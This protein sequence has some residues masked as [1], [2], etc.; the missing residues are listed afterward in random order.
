MPTTPI[1]LGQSVCTDFGQ[2]A[3]KEWLETNSLGGYASSTIAGLNTR[4]YHGLLI[5]ALEPPT[6][7][8]VLLSKVEERLL[9]DGHPHELSTNQYPGTLFPD[10][11]LFQREFR[12]DPWPTWILACGDVVLEKSI[13][14]VQGE[15]TT[16]LSYRVLE[17]SR[18][19][20]HLEIRPLVAFREHH[21]LAQANAVFSRELDSG[22]DWVSI[23]PY[24]GMPRLYL[25]HSG[26]EIARGAEWYY[27][28]EYQQE[29][30][31]GLGFHEDLYNPCCFR[32]RLR[33]GSASLIASTQRKDPAQVETMKMSER[34][35]R[36]QECQPPGGSDP[37]FGALLPAAR[38][39]VV[40]REPGKRTILA[41]YPWFSD[42]ARDALIAFPGLILST[43][44]YQDARLILGTMAGDCDRGMLPNC[45]APPGRQPFYNS[46]DSSLWLFNAVYAYV[47][48][49]DDYAFI[50]DNLY[51]TLMDIIQWYIRGTRYNIK[52]DEDGLL[53]AGVPGLQL[54]WMDAKLGEQVVTPRMGKPVEVEALWYNALKV[55]EHLASRFGDGFHQ[56]Q[57]SLHAAR[58]A[59]SFN[60]FFWNPGAHCLYDCI[61]DGV[62]DSSMR[63]NQILAVS[64]PFSMLSEAGMVQVVDAVTRELL[65]PFGLR[66]LS[67]AD[68]RYHGTYSGNV[69]QRD[70]AYHQGTVWAWLMGPYISAR[71]RSGGGTPQLR[72]ELRGLLSSLQEHLL[73]AGV[74][75]ISEIF[76]GDAPH[77]PRGCI[78]QAWSVGELLRVL[79]EDLSTPESPKAPVR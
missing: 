56:E 75:S 2:A 68:P 24:E 59:A 33:S 39:F 45:F 42:W 17:G 9:V 5:A 67:P 78:A 63:P 20:L 51:A 70:E 65:T 25:A 14:M 43:R 61:T 58:A 49:T 53:T 66:S 11:F 76:D 71:L 37:F 60:R 36:D 40:Q 18:R 13:F 38:Q 23:A 4:R 52:V 21:N 29:R 8:V 32:F 74:G 7:R 47:R 54:T 46:V 16:V 79:A 27:R 73:Q 30:D 6:S 31:R 1:S 15:N 12:L 35:L 69:K 62:P 22:S 28:F 77:A 57:C 72:S 3:A 64:L 50:R 10:G 41:G 34:A 19:E 48:H 55:M 26:A 44:R